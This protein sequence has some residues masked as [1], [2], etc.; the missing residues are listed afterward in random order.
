MIDKILT[1]PPEK[2]YTYILIYLSILKFDNNNKKRNRKIFIIINKNPLKGR[3]RLKIYPLFYITSF[4][5]F[6]DQDVCIST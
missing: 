2:Q 6:I 3:E 1:F 4:Y 5:S